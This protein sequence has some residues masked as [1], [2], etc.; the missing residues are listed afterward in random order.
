MLPV[1]VHAMHALGLNHD[2]T[3]R[4]FGVSRRSSQRWASNG[5]PLSP[6]HAELRARHVAR[7]DHALAAELA[8]SVGKTPEAFGI[9]SPAPT[10]TARLD[11]DPTHILD[12]VVCAA[13][14]AA[15][16][17]PSAVR[18]ALLAAI[19]R[20][21]QLGFTLEAV[22]AGLAAAVLTT[23]SSPAPGSPSPAPSRGRTGG[24]PA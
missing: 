12:S 8:A 10:A 24:A 5:A 23:G 21:R 9:P 22:E 1:Y 2:D 17:L 3:A 18:P 14:D 19:R 13:A 15:S 20:A 6:H 11:I 4:L 7:I 16:M